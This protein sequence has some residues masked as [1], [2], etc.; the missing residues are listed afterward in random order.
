MIELK[1]KRQI[2]LIVVTV[3]TAAPTFLVALL[4]SF[5]YYLGVESLFNDKVSRAISGTVN[6]ARLYLEE[7]KDN[8]QTDIAYTLQPVF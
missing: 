5:C 8:I 4:A 2:S 1:L 3:A 6:V 7:H